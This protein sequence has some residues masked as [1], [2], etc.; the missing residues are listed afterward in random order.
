MIIF[1]R[2]S[3]FFLPYILETLS[4]SF[5][6]VSMRVGDYYKSIAYPG[7]S[8]AAGF[9][10]DGEFF[11]SYVVTG[12]SASSRN[13]IMKEKNGGLCLLSAD[14]SIS[15]YSHL[16]YYDAYF[17]NSDYLVL[18]NG[19]HSSFIFSSLTSGL[20]LSEIISKMDYEDD[21]V[22]TARIAAVFFKKEKSYALMS[23]FKNEEGNAERRIYRYNKA[24]FIHALNTYSGSPDSISPFT[25]DPPSLFLSSSSA[26]DAAEEIYASINE[27]VRVSVFVSYK[28]EKRILNRISDERIDLKYGLNPEQKGAFC[29]KE[30]SLP[31]KVLNGKAGYINILDALNS[32]AL[33]HDMR[34]VFSSSAAASFKHVSPSG[35]AIAVPLSEDERKMYY[36]KEDESLSDIAVAYIRSRGTDRMSS[37]GDFIA[38][39]DLCDECTARI[40]KK[41][42]SDG[43]IAP[44]YSDK[45]LEILKEKKKG[46]YVILQIDENYVPNSNEKRDV[47]GIT[48]TQERNKRL[49]CLDDLKDIRTDNKEISEEK[50]RDLLLALLVLKYTQ[51]NSVAVSYSGQSIGI[52]AG[53]QSRLHSVRLACTKSERW[54]LRHHPYVLS[55]PFLDKLSR[56]DKDNVIEQYLSRDPEIDVISSWKDYFTH[57][58]VRLSE[59]E[60]HAFISSF[61]PLSLAS[62]A[63]FPFRD[64]IIRC[65]KTNIKYIAVPSGSIRD[66][67]IIDEANKRNMIVSFLQYR[68]FHH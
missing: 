24:P 43:I 54:I 45:A 26:S 11:I 60:K 1:F 28:N 30:N 25:D 42:V 53:Q 29:Y 59:E 66:C 8:I 50:K 14:D 58:I 55:L 10:Y 62:D 38:L 56:N 67:D 22:S 9:D 51:S 40:I 32:Y 13:R 4:F 34:K 5:D 16:I 23:V 7:R 46:N 18:A 49:P 37:Y 35:A 44:S 31:F 3:F 65:D 15:N 61:S 2:F 36:V 19:S 48:L 64:N 20:S 52:S 63:F 47:Y 17:E 27:D 68:L 57:E 21:E 41:E 12:R 6:Y 39:S 33:V